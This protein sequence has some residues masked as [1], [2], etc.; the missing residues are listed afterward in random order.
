M[1]VENADYYLA[2]LQRTCEFVIWIGLHAVV[3]GPE[4]PQTNCRLKRWNE[5]FLQ[6]I[7]QRN[8]DNVYVVDVWERSLLAFYET[9]IKPDAKY[10]AALARLVVMLMADPD[11]NTDI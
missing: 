10:Y 7:A 1:Y 3:E 2:M 6:K 4:I 9:E 5:E 11:T 8:Y